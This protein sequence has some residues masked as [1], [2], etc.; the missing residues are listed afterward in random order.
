MRLSVSALV[1][2]ALAG[3][4]AFAQDVISAKSGTVHYTEGR[5]LLAGH[6]V[7]QK[8]GQFPDV[9]NGQ[10]LRTEAGRAE[11]LLTP[12]VI[13]R[14]PENSAIKMVSNS[15]SDTRVEVVAGSAMVEADDTIKGDVVTLLYK[16]ASIELLKKGLY[17]V[18]ASPAQV[19]VYE[20]EAA[21]TAPSGRLTLGKG[22]ETSLEGAL[23]AV[24]FDT[25]MGDELVRWSAR[26]SEY[27]SMASVSAARSLRGSGWATS[28]WSFNPWFGMM[29]Y[30]PYSGIAY[31]P[32]GFGFWS[33]GAAA[34]YPI[35][36]Y[37]GY[38]L[39]SPYGYGGGG[40][41]AAVSSPGYTNVG[42]ANAPSFGSSMGRG[43]AIAVAPVSSGSGGGS[44]SV[45]A[46][47]G[48]GHGRH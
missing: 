25:K 4:P 45:S 31:S 43:G 23:M 46:G 42:R 3:A 19:R 20:G 10:E 38:G 30:V 33:P 12:G 32:F 40:S 5:V 28:G 34:Y 44:G 48:G 22:R 47:G 26:R 1:I 14:I 27:L 21:V 17:R 41:R 15:L 24:K 36:G 6:E 16:N 18:D 29:T 7:Q 11:V 2:G 39:Y 35:W 8:Y 9:K 37:G 13:L